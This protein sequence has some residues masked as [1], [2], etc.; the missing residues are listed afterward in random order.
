MAA[1]RERYPEIA[2]TQDRAV[3]LARGGAEEG[4]RVV[5]ARQSSGRGRYGHSWESPEGGLY[6]SIVLAAPEH[7]S[8]LFPI[9]LSAVLA[10]E[11]GRGSSAPLA[12]RWP[13]DLLE[14][15]ASAPVQKLGGV[16]VDDVPSPRYGRALVA[17]IGLNV[18]TERS[19]FPPA[20]RA[21]VA[22]LSELVSEPPV[23][24]EVEERV[25]HAALRTASIFRDPEGRT[26]LREL[27]RR[28]LWGIGRAVKI[29]GG[30]VGRI[31]GLGDEG[32]LLVEDRGRRRVFWTGVLEVEESP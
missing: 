10:S 14:V 7:R 4:T 20:V 19:A 18:T 29:D 23:L 16:L 15:P 3:A 8:S 9:A 21:R 13:N 24:T 31:A 32:E 25:V 28:L 22:V 17:G 30:P 2:S 27:G 1:V 11:L 12:V 5:A 26:E 6:L